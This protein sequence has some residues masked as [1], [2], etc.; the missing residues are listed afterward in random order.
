MNKILPVI[1]ALFLFSAAGLYAQEA[2][3]SEP[4][5]MMIGVTMGVGYFFDTEDSSENFNL[6]LK[7]PINNN[8]GVQ[9]SMGSYTIPFGDKEAG[10]LAGEAYYTNIQLDALYY[11]FFHRNLQVRA[12]VDYYR[13]NNGSSVNAGQ[14]IST[15]DHVWR[16]NIFGVHLALNIDVP[17]YEKA[18]IMGSV[19]GRY[20]INDENEK[21]ALDVSLGLGYRL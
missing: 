15:I 5:Y 21:F 8:F 20:F 11:T 6:L 4:S 3:K 10:V 19:G 2:K 12:G 1:V 18:Y 9:A 14:E 17:L 16:K 7:T 13:Y